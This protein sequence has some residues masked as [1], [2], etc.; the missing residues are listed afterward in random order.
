[1]ETTQQTSKQYFRTLSIMHIALIIGLVFFSLI[2]IYLIISRQLTG[3]IGLAHIFLYIVS[4]F[5]LAGLFGSNL[6]YKNKIAKIKTN[7]DL[8]AKMT[9]YRSAMI[10]RWAFLE[11]PAFL[12]IV[13]IMLSS[14]LIFLSFTGL[15]IARMIYLRPTMKTAI[16][17]LELDQKEIAIMEDPESILIEFPKMEQY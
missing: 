7:N 13:A 2:V 10:I 17:D 8:M 15:I 1:M 9:N 12:S 4:L 14:N 3:D 16:F 5:T 6:I 11:G